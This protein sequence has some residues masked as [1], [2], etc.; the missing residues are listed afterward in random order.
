MRDR[1]KNWR[2]ADAER[3]LAQLEKSGESVAGYERRTGIPASRL[4]WWRK[5]LAADQSEGPRFVPVRVTGEVTTAALE[6]VVGARVVRVRDGFDDEI[7]L[8]LIRV[9]E[10]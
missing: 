5:R 7:L 6:I 2:A 1:R 8:R 9:L 4:H 10:T 3:A